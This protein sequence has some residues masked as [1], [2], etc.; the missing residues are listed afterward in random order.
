MLDID[1][2]AHVLSSFSKLKGT[3]V[4]IYNPSD[5]KFISDW[6]T[7]QGISIDPRRDDGEVSYWVKFTEPRWEPQLVD[8]SVVFT[9]DN[10]L[11]HKD[12]IDGL[13][14]SVSLLQLL[15]DARSVFLTS[16]RSIE[17]LLLSW[18]DIE[19]D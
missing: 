4:A 3:Q 12:E 13:V 19:P 9:H 5:R 15:P 16:L 14:L 11:R 17:K 1:K 7:I 10:L 8:E 18:V 2:F 6:A